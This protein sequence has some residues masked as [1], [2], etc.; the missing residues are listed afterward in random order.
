MEFNMSTKWKSVST[1]FLSYSVLFF[2]YFFATPLF[3]QQ[4]LQSTL[5]VQATLLSTCTL[6][7]VTN[8]GFPPIFTTTT[9]Y[10]D[11][12]GIIA[13]TC[14]PSTTL[15]IG[16]DRGGIDPYV[17]TRQMRHNTASE[18]TINYNLYYNFP[19]GPLSVWGDGII[20][21]ASTKTYISPATTAPFNAYVY[22]NLP[23]GQPITLTGSYSDTVG[24]YFDF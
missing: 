5:A 3:A 17:D 2:A 7:S 24:I 23:E 11:G 8:I 22:A 4:T 21:D 10:R 1:H 18:N 15:V 9:P 14:S 20:P 16:L 13:I 6:D 19:V 12:T